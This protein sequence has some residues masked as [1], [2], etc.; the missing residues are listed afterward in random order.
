MTKW[1]GMHKSRPKLRLY[2]DSV[3]LMEK[4]GMLAGFLAAGCLYAFSSSS[5]I[6]CSH[7]GRCAYARI[8]I[9]AIG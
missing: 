1:V 2:T 4:H 9:R 6:R 7:T 5:S 8:V 3:A